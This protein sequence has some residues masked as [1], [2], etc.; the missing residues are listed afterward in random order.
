MKTILKFLVVYSLLV[1]V[2]VFFYDSKNSVYEQKISMLDKQVQ[3]VTYLKN[4]YVLSIA[5][6]KYMSDTQDSRELLEKPLMI[7]KP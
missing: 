3:G 7:I 1:G 4:L 2:I 6:A 5:Y